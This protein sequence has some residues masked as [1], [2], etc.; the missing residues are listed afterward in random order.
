MAVIFA[1]S[2]RA[3]IPGVQHGMLDFVL[4]KSLHAAGYGVLAWLWWR[5]LD[6]AGVRRSIPWA[7]MLTVAYAVTDEWH[8]SFVEG[9]SGRV[10][11]VLI[12]ALGAAVALALVHR[13]TARRRLPG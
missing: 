9:R 5:A 6:S 2:H 12:D 8:Q 13:W 1:L 11:D 4:K 10:T 7:F 3:D